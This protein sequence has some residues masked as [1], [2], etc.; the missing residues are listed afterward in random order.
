M[1]GHLDG[2]D[3]PWRHLHVAR[4]QA[5]NEAQKGR[6]RIRRMRSHFGGKTPWL[7]SWP[8]GGPGLRKARGRDENDPGP[9][10]WVEDSR[11]Q[12]LPQPAAPRMDGTHDG[13]PVP[14]RTPGP[15]TFQRQTRPRREGRP[16]W[17]TSRLWSNA[18]SSRP[19]P[20]TKAHWKE[21]LLRRLWSHPVSA[22]LAPSTET[23]PTSCQRP[24]SR[25]VF[26]RCKRSQPNVTP[27]SL[28]CYA[29]L[30]PKPMIW[31]LGLKLVSGP[32]PHP[33]FLELT[34]KSK[35]LKPQTLFLNYFF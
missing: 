21:H 28:F 7:S 13:S 30:N 8:Q 15:S 16:L 3:V 11:R 5:Q 10:A 35:K 25:M 26:S 9:T 18:W 29:E 19:E 14:A 22:T 31:I 17:R 2:A 12:A 34:G 4:R 33:S 6:T 24:R 20:Q 23:A 27:F 32:C 1:L